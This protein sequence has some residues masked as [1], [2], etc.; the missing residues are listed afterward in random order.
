MAGTVRR[1]RALSQPSS[2]PFK[3]F[4]RRNYRQPRQHNLAPHSQRQRNRAEYNAA[5]LRN[6]ELQ[7]KRRRKYAQH[8]MIVGQV[9]E[10]AF[11]GQFAAVKRVQQLE[12]NE[13]REEHRPFLF[14][15]AVQK[16]P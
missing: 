6:H 4:R 12:N 14:R 15:K 11:I 1:R 9:L 16:I 7:Q 3:R 8:Q 10:N 13:K 5:V 2:D